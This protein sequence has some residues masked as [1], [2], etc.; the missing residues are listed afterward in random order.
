MADVTKW[1]LPALAGMFSATAARRVDWANDTVKLA[2][3]R[4]TWTPDQDADDFWNDVSSHECV[5]T[6]YTAGGV[7]LTGKVVNTDPATNVVSLDADDVTLTGLTLDGAN[8]PAFYVIYKDTGSAV[9]SPI[10]GHVIL[11]P[12]LPVTA[13]TL[14]IVWTATGLLKITA[15]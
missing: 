13:G 12:T 11:D 10:L 8:T 7:A 3:L 9:T 14:S 5:G 6:G 4:S 15:S 1:N 2:I